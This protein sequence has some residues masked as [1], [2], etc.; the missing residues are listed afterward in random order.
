MKFEEAL[1]AMREGKKVRVSDWSTSNFIRIFDNPTK[2]IDKNG[3]N[4]N[5]TSFDLLCEDWEVYEEPKWEPQNGEWYVN[6]LGSVNRHCGLRKE[7]SNF[8]MTRKTRKQ[9]EKARDKMR[10]FNRLLAYVDEHAPDYEPDW[11]NR[12]QGKYYVRLDHS[13]CK[14]HVYSNFFEQ[15]GGKVYMP[16]EVAEK[17]ADD[18]N[19]GRVEL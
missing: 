9:A 10:I 3:D 12:V 1:A 11:C 17:L 5:L 18:L 2:F 4:L 16:R 6:S 8:G 19:N 14:W 15:D 13:E 7:V